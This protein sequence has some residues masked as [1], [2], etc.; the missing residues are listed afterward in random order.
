MS[1]AGACVVDN[2]ASA[3]TATGRVRLANALPRLDRRGDGDGF[4]CRRLSRPYF[5]ALPVG[6]NHQT[7]PQDSRIDAYGGRDSGC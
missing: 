1:S 6:P 2:A 4:S 7:G 5:V 3:S